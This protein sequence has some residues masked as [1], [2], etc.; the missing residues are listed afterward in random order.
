V[1]GAAEPEWAA[2]Y[3]RHRALMYRVATRQLAGVGLTAQAEDVVMDA[4]Y[5]LMKSPPKSPVENW[6]AVLVTV[7]KR[8]AID[9]IRSADVRHAGATGDPPDVADPLED[10]A[11]EVTAAL[12]AQEDGALLWDAL[13]VLED[14]ERD[15]LWRHKALDIS[16][17]KIAVEYGVS[18]SR[19]SQISTAAMRKL[20]P[21]LREEGVER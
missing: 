5:S 19:V 11:D 4:F 21:V 1:P 13:S 20:E 6:E 16:R 10:V 18:P 17:E 2:L 15:V 9:L 14:R 3:S 12:A 7:V 8:K